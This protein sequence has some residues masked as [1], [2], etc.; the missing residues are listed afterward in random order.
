MAFVGQKVGET[1]FGKCGACG[2]ANAASENC[3]GFG[4]EYIYVGPSGACGRCGFNCVGSA[5]TAGDLGVCKKTAYLGEKAECCLDMQP[6]GFPF[7]TCDPDIHSLAP[8]CS[9]IVQS[10]CAGSNIFTQPLCKNWAAKNPDLAFNIKKTF[11]T[12]DKIKTDQN[13]R[14][15]VANEAQGK[16]DDI[17]VLDYCQK[18]PTDPLCSCIISEFICPNKFDSR[19]IQKGGYK[20]KD[21]ATTVCPSVLNCTQQINISPDALSFGVNVEQNCGSNDTGQNSTFKF[22]Q[23]IIILIFIFI[24]LIAIIFGIIYYMNKNQNILK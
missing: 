21:M 22:D 11:C 4:P 12:S 7:R 1:R 19:C 23:N 9:S 24:I 6:T 20:T 5:C 10:N 16:I 18:N 3:S 17:M 13:C 14:N 2:P 8:V 15:F